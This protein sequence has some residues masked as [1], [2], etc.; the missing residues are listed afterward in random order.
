MT[1]ATTVVKICALCIFPG[2]H[3]SGEVSAT[4]PNNG[5]NALVNPDLPPGYTTLVEENPT[6]YKVSVNFDR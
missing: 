5:G 6:K 2:F 4:R 3:L 1:N